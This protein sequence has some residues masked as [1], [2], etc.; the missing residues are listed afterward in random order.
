MILKE[1]NSDIAL[2][3]FSEIFD[4]IRAQVVEGNY[5]LIFSSSYTINTHIRLRS[6]RGNIYLIDAFSMLPANVISLFLLPPST[7]FSGDYRSTHIRNALELMKAGVLIW[8][9]RAVHS[10]F[11]LFWSF[12]QRQ[13]I[14]H[15]RYYGSTNFTKGG[16]IKNIEEFYHGRRSLRF[17]I[18]LPRSHI[19]YLDTALKRI[20]EITKM[21]E[22]PDYLAKNL[23]DLQNKIPKILDNLKQRMT[24]AKDLKN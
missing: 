11:L 18:N 3:S 10:K 21:H 4:D 22:S 15:R 5:G 17:N 19:F 12:N 13:F 7:K 20:D 23:S 24:S 6:S 16:L 1:K 14:E 2:R 9:D 8:F